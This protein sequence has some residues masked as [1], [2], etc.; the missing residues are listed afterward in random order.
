M[1][2]GDNRRTAAAIAGTLGIEVQAELMP[3]DKV[4][5]MQALAAKRPGR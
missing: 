1:L 5:A 3:D 2:T 4:A